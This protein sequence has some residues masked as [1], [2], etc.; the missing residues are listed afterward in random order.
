[1]HR[2]RVREASSATTPVA[3]LSWNPA[4]LASLDAP[5]VDLALAAISARGT[6]ANRVDSNGLLDDAQGVVP[7]GAVAF[8]FQQRRLVFA[9]A[10]SPT[11]RLPGRGRIGMRLARLV[12]PTESPRTGR[13]SSCSGRPRVSARSL[14]S[15][16]SVGGSLSLLW[17]H[18][19]LS[20]PYIFQTQ[21][22]LVGLKTM[23]DV[24]ASGTGWGASLGA[25][26]KASRNG[27]GR[28]VVAVA[29]DIDDAWRRRWR[30]LGAVRGRSA[31]RP[32]PR[33]RS[34]AA[35]RNSFPSMVAA[36]VTWEATAAHCGSRD[37][38]S[39][40]AGTTRSHRCPSR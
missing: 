17:N 7:E 27:D 3:A 14:G 34:S 12:R 32:T 28:C 8:P 16:V 29:D 30:R 38:S 9:A 18:N 25:V 39:A 10:C 26:V 5:E 21:A 15:R 22:P 20:A 33:S 37:S 35:V 1:M 24:E 6:F 36:A 11:A 31:S 23:L 2:W 13:G 19:E 40:G 4:G